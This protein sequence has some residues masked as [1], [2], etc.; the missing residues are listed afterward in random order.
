MGSCPD[1]SVKRTRRASVVRSS[2]PQPGPQ[3][4]IGVT[5]QELLSRGR[6]TFCLRVALLSPVRRLWGE[7]HYLAFAQQVTVDF[8]MLQC[9]LEHLQAVG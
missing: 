4:Q 1:T 5:R 2:W 8:K 9:L 6:K 3:G 7:Q